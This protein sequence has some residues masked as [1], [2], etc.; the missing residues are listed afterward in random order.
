MDLARA[1]R[2]GG[3]GGGGGPSL[4]PPSSA[5]RGS[6][7]LR[8]CACLHE[9]VHETTVLLRT[10]TASPCPSAFG[11][12][13]HKLCPSA[14]VIFLPDRISPCATELQPA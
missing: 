6:H 4:A 13:F 5:L 14:T 10:T 12:V 2:G 7:R 8:P 3:G 11:L 9:G 1:E